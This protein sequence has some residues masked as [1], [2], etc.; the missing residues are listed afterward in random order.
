[1]GLLFSHPEWL[2]PGLAF[3]A[4]VGV[5][6]V[7][8]GL[9]TRRDLRALLGEA[10][11]SRS[12]HR[13]NLARMSRN[14]ALFAAL[15]LI[16][17]GLLGPRIG[18]EDVR[19][20]TSGI[21]VVIVFDTS[22]S[23]DAPD[24][25]PSRMEA[26]RRVAL[27]FLAQFGSG[28]R[29]ALGAFAG[30]GVLLTPLTSDHAALAEM[31]ATLETTL[32]KPGG[33]NLPDGIRAALKAFDP[34]AERPRAILLLSDG[35]NPGHPIDEGL[36][37]AARANVRIF[38]VAFGSAEG[39]TIPDHGAPLRDSQGEIVTSRRRLAPL[40]AAADVTDGRLFVADEW[41]HLEAATA[42]AVLRAP[43]AS[44]DG[45]FVE[46]PMIV[47]VVVP[48]AI[49]ALLLL[50]LDWLTPGWPSQPR[51]S[52]PSRPGRL[53]VVVLCA[54]SLAATPNSASDVPVPSAEQLLAAGLDH[55]AHGSWERARASFLDAALA[56]KNPEL[57]AIAYHDLG[58]AALRLRDLEAARGAFFDALAASGE[59]GAPA[60]V[61]R[62]QWNLEWT[63]EQLAAE[64]PSEPAPAPPGPE[65][66]RKQKTQP[67][68]PQAAEERS[69]TRREPASAFE[70]PR[71]RDPVAAR[72]LPESLP[73]LGPAQRE[74]WLA[75]VQD[76]PRRALLSASFEPHDERRRR[77][78][79]RPT[80]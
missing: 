50:L 51:K 30:R 70:E 8:A 25:P 1:M 58:V 56:A 7:W 80:W 33:S 17:L 60:R 32:V 5:A 76:D 61:T 28:D 31:T 78:L 3:L 73:E 6:L 71:G 2:A 68:E 62:T 75:R 29:A 66:R 35:E 49:A 12:Q 20:S 67:S 26:A 14:A 64:S 65:D 69:A 79:G 72:R 22:R 24:I 54:A 45:E 18:L 48:F 9:R 74:S 34:L 42:L 43:V 36:V 40:R 39:A 13:R 38:P 23:M 63:L 46:Q 59:G 27:S 19:V 15:L 47:A 4:A 77:K 16:L 53:G 44:T 41:G 11:A 37:A 55:A 57:R 10:A 52:A 21:D